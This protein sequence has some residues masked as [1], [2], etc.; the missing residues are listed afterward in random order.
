MEDK[1]ITIIINQQ[2][3]HFSTSTL[4][5]DDFRDLGVDEKSQSREEVRPPGYG[6]AEIIKDSVVGPLE[7]GRIQREWKHLNRNRDLDYSERCSDTSATCSHEPSSMS[8][9]G[10]F[11]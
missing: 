8:M 2:P 5:P 4:T 6:C 10:T 7:L 11:P 3:Y 9:G 1:K